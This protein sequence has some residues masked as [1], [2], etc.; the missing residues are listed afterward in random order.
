MF[1]VD[2]NIPSELQKLMSVFHGD[3]RMNDIEMKLSL[4][5]RFAK[6]GSENL[7]VDPVRFGQM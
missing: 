4:S 1:D 7:M 3:Q 2:T 6:L 5:D